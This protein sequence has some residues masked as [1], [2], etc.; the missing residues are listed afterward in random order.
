MSS[1]EA[2]PIGLLRRMAAGD[3]TDDELNL[4]QA[5]LQHEG[6]T[7]PPR[8]ALQR[9]H[10]IPRGERPSLVRRLAAAL[11]SDS[12]HRPVLAGARGP[13]PSRYL[14]YAAGDTE[15]ALELTTAQAGSES[16]VGQV[17]GES[18]WSTAQVE[19][20]RG[21][22]SDTAIDAAG[23]F[24]FDPVLRPQTVTVRGEAEEI[25]LEIPHEESGDG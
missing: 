5:W 18:R 21:E 7:E 3:L 15:I 23:M 12:G 22:R 20:E 1:E 19:T 13:S 10:R 11:V 2:V 24:A 8:W 6:L 17:A 14:I 16:V 9:A 4:V 25:V